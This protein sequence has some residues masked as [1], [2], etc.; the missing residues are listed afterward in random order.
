MELTQDSYDQSGLVIGKAF[1]EACDDLTPRRL[2]SIVDGVPATLP[3]I[4]AE[5]RHTEPATITFVLTCDVCG[6]L[7]AAPHESIWLEN[8]RQD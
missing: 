3:L 8:V 4:G 7:S 5:D 2:R 1:C 6:L